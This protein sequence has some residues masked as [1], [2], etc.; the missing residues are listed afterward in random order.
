VS[1]SLADRLGRMK[2]TGAALVRPA[3]PRPAGDRELPGW[4]RRG[5]HLYFRSVRYPPELHDRMS[6]MLV[7]VDSLE[8]G[9]LHF[10]DT[11][12]TGL[13]TGAGTIAFL[14]GAGSHEEDSFVVRQLFL[15]DFPGEPSWLDELERLIS[16]DAILVSY[17]GGSFD[18]PLLR[19][20]FAMH[21]R[22]FPERPHIDLLHHARRLWKD[23]I[24]SCSLSAI[25]SHVFRDPRASDVPGVEIPDRYFSFLR[26]GDASVMSGV[27]EHHALDIVSLY[28]LFGR[29][30][31]ILGDPLSDDVDLYRTGIWLDNR[32]SSIG[33]SV[34]RTAWERGDPKA[35]LELA[36][37]LRRAGNAEE[38]TA[39]WL[40]LWR[41]LS[42]VRAA[43]ELAK[44]LE[45]REKSYEAAL[46]LIEQCLSGSPIRASRK[47]VDHDMS[48]EA[49][50][51]RKRR[52]EQKI[53][54]GGSG[55]T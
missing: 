7:G 42:S 38:A 4:E 53:T 46:D 29:C 13:S 51:H 52:L 34:L 19:S 44:Y 35:G 40:D 12:T 8:A 27:F 49:L 43:V 54:R 21:G 10:F 3:A 6:S 25:E 47:A 39:I 9:R 24:G 23:R 28:R 45:H 31:R 2:A 20:R 11:E 36:R 1:G 26:S 48:R 5:E 22:R 50:E 37:R 16:T 18:L 33:L 41:R 17:N 55:T 32:G 15:S 30:E 14:Y